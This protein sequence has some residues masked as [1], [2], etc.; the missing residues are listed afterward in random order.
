MIEVVCDKCD[1]SGRWLDTKK[2]RLS[3]IHE[4]RACPECESEDLIDLDAVGPDDYE[5][6]ERRDRID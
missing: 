4:V 6:Q 5:K 1:W 3:K 2:V